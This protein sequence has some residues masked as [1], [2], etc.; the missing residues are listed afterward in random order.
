MSNANARLRATIIENTIFLFILPPNES[1]EK[2]DLKS[3][4]DPG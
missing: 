2:V 4:I 3:I 1:V